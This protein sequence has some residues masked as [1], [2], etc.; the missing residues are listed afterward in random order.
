MQN[1]KLSTKWNPFAG[2]KQCL[3]Q[4]WLSL[5]HLSTKWNPFAGLKL[6]WIAGSVETTS[7]F[8]L[9]E[10]RSRDWNRLLQLKP[11]RRP[12]FQLNETRSRDWNIFSPRRPVV[13]IVI[14][15]TKWNPFAGLKLYAQ[16]SVT[17]GSELSTKWNPF[18]G[19]KRLTSY[20]SR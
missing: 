18:A 4:G 13:T 5:F 12:Y 15:S 14:L 9:N 11:V 20:V 2:L 8:Q 6:T 19:L 10:T 3:M 1:K 16:G 7:C 17:V